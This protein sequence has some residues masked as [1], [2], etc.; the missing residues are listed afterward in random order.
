LVHEAGGQLMRI[1][2]LSWKNLRKARAIRTSIGVLGAKYLRVVLN[3]SRFY[4]EPADIYE[5]VAADLPVILTMWHG[6]HLLAP[7][8][9]RPEHRAK[10]LISHHRDAEVNAIAA[11]RLG[12]EIIRG[13]GDHGSEFSRKGGVNAFLDMLAALRD[14]YNIALTADVPKVSRVAGLGIVKLSHA[15]ERPIYPIAIASRRR[16]ELDTWDRMTIN[17]PFSRVVV[18]VAEPVRVPADADDAMLEAYRKHIE[19]ALNEVTERAYAMV[20]R[21]Q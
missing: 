10:V 4:Y 3:T 19:T 6:Q 9:K 11:E 7:F 2:M 12:I 1:A 16:I 13:S 17:L 15:S 8:V 5:R 18:L 21:L 20:D 14:G